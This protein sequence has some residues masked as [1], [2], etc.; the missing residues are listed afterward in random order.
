[1]AVEG[2]NQFISFETHRKHISRLH[3]LITVCFVA[4]IGAMTASYAYYQI[5]AK[6]GQLS[7]STL[8]VTLEIVSAIGD[9]FFLMVLL[10]VALGWTL[11]DSIS[12]RRV[13]N[14]FSMAFFLYFLFRVLYAF[15]RQPSLCPAYILSYRIIKL[16][17]I[18]G[19][20]MSINQSIERLRIASLE[21]Q[22]SGDTSEVFIKMKML[23]TFRTSYYLYLAAP[24]LVFFLQYAIISWV[25]YWVLDAA[26]QLINFFMMW[27]VCTTFSPKKYTLADSDELVPPTL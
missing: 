8:E 24:I 14:T 27:I 6:H 4:Q 2:L 15:C 5:L 25:N 18:F 23:K 1:M 3:I 13:Q 17:L 9:T 7:S 11:I 26:E 21:Q 10:L 12:I 20:I 19:I 22:F 16:M